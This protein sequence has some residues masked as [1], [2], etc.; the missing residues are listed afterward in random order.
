M[1]AASVDALVVTALPNILYLTNFGGSAAIVVID[2]ERIRFITDSRYVAAVTAMQHAAHACP[3]L[4]IV[5]V[6]GSYD[7]TLADVLLQGSVQGGACLV[8]FEAA[9]LT[10]SRY[11]WLTATL[12][13]EI[14]RAHV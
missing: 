6:G 12:S 5:T 11:D 1:A 7:A 3:G 4:E 9:H 10:V 2:R 8:G 13:A 14:G